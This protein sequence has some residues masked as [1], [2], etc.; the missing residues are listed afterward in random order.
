MLALKYACVDT[1][2]TTDIYNVTSST[3]VTF[4]DF[5]DAVAATLGLSVKEV[6][7]AEA[8]EKAGP[9]IAG[10]FSIRN[11]G[12]SDKAKRELRWIPSEADIVA[13][14]RNGSYVQVA[15]ELKGTVGA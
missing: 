12:K 9:L 5:T 10:F 11:R 3:E 15:K 2:R 6:S 7:A 14:I 8:A 4:R 1:D 13:D